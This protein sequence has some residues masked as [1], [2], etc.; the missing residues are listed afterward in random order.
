MQPSIPENPPVSID[1]D[2]G[3]TAVSS[4]VSPPSTQI[5]A[6][7]S[8]PAPSKKPTIRSDSVKTHLSRELQHYY[9]R[10]V[11][12]LSIP[13][14]ERK[15]TAALTSLRA[16]AGLQQVL[17][18]LVRWVGEGVVGALRRDANEGDEMDVD[19]RSLEVF[20][21]VI[22]ALLENDRLF[23]EPYV[24]LSFTYLDYRGL[25]AMPPPATS[26]IASHPFHFA[27]R[28]SFRS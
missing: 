21:Q 8:Q 11:S 18:Y 22:G 25:R 19:R 2:S 27:H 4:L 28:D 13:S 12:A 16:D 14:D 10:L 26:T 5:G 6:T 3:Q 20:L 7:Q 24:R 1:V 17:P 9:T 15:K 23:V